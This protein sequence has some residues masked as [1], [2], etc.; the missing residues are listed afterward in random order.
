MSESE[1][2]TQ[3]D[4][5]RRLTVT[6]TEDLIAG[7]EDYAEENGC[8]L[9]DAVR[10][11]VRDHFR[12]TCW[13]TIGAIAEEAI[14]AGDT[15]DEVL[16]KVREQRPEA[17]TTLASISWYRSRLRSEHGRDKILTDAGVRRSR[18]KRRQ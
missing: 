14:L 5:A 7:L 9:S 10:E 8:S 4:A 15:N 3:T 1:R 12:Q 13:E 16:E 11:I 6:L 2:E 18:S 17:A